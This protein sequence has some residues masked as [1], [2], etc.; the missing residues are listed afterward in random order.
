M[1]HSG[2]PVACNFDCGGGCSLLAYTSNGKIT[3][4]IDNPEAGK[5]HR[6]C[7]RGLQQARIQGARDRLT[8]PLIRTGP[9]GSGE[10]REASWDEALDM[11]ADRLKTIKEEHGMESVI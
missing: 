4:L 11:V 8:S 10:F 9:R 7:V 1:D 5:H 2:V 6:A 3:K